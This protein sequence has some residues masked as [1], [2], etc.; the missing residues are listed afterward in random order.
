MSTRTQLNDLIGFE[1]TKLGFFREVQ[2]KIAELEES[3]AAL[4]AKQQEIRNILDGVTDI[5]ALVTPDRKIQGVNQL[6]LDFYGIDKPEGRH[7][8]EVFRR[9][10]NP[11]R[12]CPQKTAGKTGKLCRKTFLEEHHGKQVY[13][14]VTASPLFDE[15]GEI[16]NFLIAK[17]DVTLEKAYQAKYYQAE[18]MATI[19]VLAAGVA[20]EVNNPLTAISGFS[21]GLKRRIPQMHQL[22]D[23]IEGGRDLAD[24]IEDYTLTILEECNR[25]RDIVSNLLSFSRQKSG[26]FTLI[27]LNVVIQ[28]TLKLVRRIREQ[29]DGRL[30]L[31]YAPE[32]LLIQGDASELKQVILNMVVNAFDA[33]KGDGDITIRTTSCAAGDSA[34][35]SIE[36]TG[37]GIPETNMDKLFVPFFTTKSAGKGIGIG[38][39][40]CYSIIKKHGGQIDVSSQEGCGSIFTIRLPLPEANE[41]LS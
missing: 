14:E 35:V 13:F 33:V 24:D 38:L 7:C 37:I 20:H 41:P 22:L 28:E 1:Y 19:G 15:R 30:H 25:C 29:S 27:D 31:E 11:C 40:I 17:R 34:L 39:A 6:F 16:R 21:E 18:K 26:V 3:N 32:P 36:D 8:Y 4:Q 12:D 5:L 9:K 2:E 23:N 10:K